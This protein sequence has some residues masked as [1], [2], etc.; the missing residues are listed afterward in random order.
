MQNEAASTGKEGFAPAERIVRAGRRNRGAGSKKP[1]RTDW[2]ASRRQKEAVALAEG[3]AFA[4]SKNPSRRQTQAVAHRIGSLALVR[5][6][7]PVWIKKPSRLQQES[8]SLAGG[9]L[10][11]ADESGHVCRRKAPEWSK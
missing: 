4:S 9:G 5:R 8:L 3:N 6:T 10:A 1:F 2:E 7:L 11:H